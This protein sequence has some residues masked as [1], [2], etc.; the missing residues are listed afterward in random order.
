MIEDMDD[1]AL[2]VGDMVDQMRTRETLDS[3][4]S[5]VRLMSQYDWLTTKCIDSSK[6]LFL[7]D[8]GDLV[9]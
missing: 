3:V 6:C 2:E 8:M 7:A 4:M 5:I 9:R 1:L